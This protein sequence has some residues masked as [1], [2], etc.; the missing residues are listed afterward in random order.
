MSKVNKEKTAGPAGRRKNGAGTIS[1]D[2]RN[3]NR[4][5]VRAPGKKRQYLGSYPDIQ[6]AEKALDDFFRRGRPELFNA[7]VSD[8]YRMWSRS[9]F[10]ELSAKS[11]ESYRGSWK[12]F[13]PIAGMKM[14]KVRAVHFQA[15]V[16]EHN[17]AGIS[18]D[19]KTLAR[20]LCRFSMEN[21]IID[22]DYSQ[23]IRLPRYEKNQKQIF[24]RE[25]IALLWKNSGQP[26][27]Q[28]V[29]VM[30]YMGFRIGEM[31]SLRAED[32]HIGE[33]YITGGIKTEAGRNRI[34]PFP[35]GVPEIKSFIMRRLELP[36]GDGRLYPCTV[37]VFR[38]DMFYRP[39]IRLGI[40]DAHYGRGG[41]IVFHS[42]RHLTPHSARHTFATLSVEAGMRP[43]YLQRIIGHATYRTT[44]D[45]YVH[46]DFS[47]LAAEMD[48]LCKL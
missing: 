21:D 42:Q 10:P 26:D 30:I 5:V 41:N 45:Y 44:S 36:D 20:A 47:R 38:K 13:E 24:T 28:A 27:V 32:V 11:V 22:K 46:P 17:G 43:E 19:I 15:L 31:T 6:S 9:K 4:Y 25:Q 1:L 35:C 33:N 14:N 16:D 2:R 18:R 48:K 8:I 23:Y 29:L 39:L 12:H 7:S 34:V 40:L 3:C 37:S